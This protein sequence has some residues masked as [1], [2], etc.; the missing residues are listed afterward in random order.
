MSEEQ[1]AFLKAPQSKKMLTLVGIYIATI[2][3]MIQ[4]NG[5]S[6]V[7][8][9]AGAEFDAMAIYSLASSLGGPVSVVLMPLWGYIGARNP[10]LKSRLL[11]ISVFIGAAS[12]LVRA[13]ATNYLIVIITGITYCFTTAGIFV[14]GF[15]LIRDIFPGKQ[16]GVYLGLVGT[17][18][19]LGSIVGPTLTGAIL[20]ALGWR[21]ACHIIWPFLVIGA[22]MCLFGV[23]ITKA[24]GKE[25]SNSSGSLDFVGIICVVFFLGPLILA[26]ALGSGMIPFGSPVSTALFA[27][28]VVALI[29]LI[30]IIRKK[31]DS[32]VV[33]VSAFTD[34]NT[35]CIF[36]SYFFTSFANMFVFFFLPAYIMY[37]L[38][39]SDL[40]LTPALW[41]GIA[42]ACFAVFSLFLSPVFGRMIAKA[43]NARTVL[44]FNVASR[45]ILLGCFILFLNPETSIWVLLIICFIP[46]GIYT[47]AQSVAYTTGINIMA[48]AKLRTQ[49]NALV[50]MG[51]TLGSSPGVAVG[52]VLI[53]LFGV[54]EGMPIAFMVA[55]GICVVAL[56][57]SL[58]LR[59]PKEEQQ[60]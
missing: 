42:M 23:N 60:D 59:T 7:F 35:V 56:I 38:Q 19:G 15:S 24:E 9:A 2:I 25:L 3:A 37:V 10:H 50:Q 48:P 34:R 45:I 13:F 16:A 12:V 22:L 40:G 54:A 14:C 44:I 53:A 39:P 11:V 36:L 6:L 51:Q 5:A 43:R 20:G 4:S 28:A 18:I 33:P 27:V 31:G 57:P 29:A 41:S 55:A 21:W 8:P 26:I 46:G 1:N 52:G 49:S 17:M 47:T 30:V 58:L 32:A